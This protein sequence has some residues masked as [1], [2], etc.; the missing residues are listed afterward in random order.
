MTRTKVRFKAGF[1][2]YVI[3]D[4]ATF[5]SGVAD[6]LIRQGF[7]A[8]VGDVKVSDKSIHAPDLTRGNA[9][10]DKNRAKGQAAKNESDSGADAAPPEPVRHHQKKS[11]HKKKNA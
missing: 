4:I 10:A 7:A 11:H 8:K 6:G 2:G 3:G 9:W 5:D 1:E